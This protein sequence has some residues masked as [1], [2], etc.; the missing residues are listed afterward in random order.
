M[1]TDAPEWYTYTDD[2]QSYFY[3]LRASQN[4]WA[5][6][7]ISVLLDKE[8]P[9]IIV[10]LGSGMGALT[11]LLGIWAK[12]KGA[13]FHAYDR[14]PQLQLRD[15]YEPLGI[16]FFEEDCLK[17]PALDRMAELRAAGKKMLILCDNGNK[18]EEISKYKDFM[19]PGDI[20][21]V[22]DYQRDGNAGYMKS[23]GYWAWCESNIGSGV[24]HGLEPVYETLLEY[25][26]WGAFRKP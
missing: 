20:I 2:W 21:M 8:N 5:Y 16:K 10:E 13:T 4:M 12:M 3:G 1:I 14:N 15:L 26:A 17:G 18:N 23:R 7:V 24:D 11:I 6:S 19:N 9:G 25:A 22:H